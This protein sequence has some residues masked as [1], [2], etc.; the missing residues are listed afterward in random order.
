MTHHRAKQSMH[1]WCGEIGFLLQK[2]WYKNHSAQTLVSDKIGLFRTGHMVKETSKV[3]IQ[4]FTLG[5]IVMMESD[6][7]ENSP[8]TRYEH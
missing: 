5:S 1:T 7:Q 6:K 4:L 8:E 3:S 2:T